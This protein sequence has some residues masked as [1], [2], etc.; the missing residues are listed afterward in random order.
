MERAGGAVPFNSYEFI[1]LFFPLVYVGLCLCRRAGWLRLVKLWLILVSLGFYIWG[2]PS[3]GLLLLGSLV[4][5]YLF[6]WGIGREGSAC[7]RANDGGNARIRVWLVGGIGINVALLLYFK[8]TNFFLDSIAEVLDVAVMRLDI[9]LPLGISFITFQQIAFL[10]DTYR[11]RLSSI[12]IIDYV[13]FMCFFPQLTAGPIVR[14]QEMVPQYVSLGRSSGQ[15]AAGIFLFCIGMF[16]KTVI[17]DTLAIWVRDGYARSDDILGLVDAWI[18]TLSYTFQLYFD[19]SGYSDM[20][21]G[22]AL[23][24]GIRLPINFNSPYQATSLQDFWRRWHMTLSAFLREFVYVPLGGN[25]QGR[26]IT[27]RNLFLTFLI[28]GVWHGAAWGFVIWGAIHGLAL[29]VHRLW[30]ACKFELPSWFG[31]LLTFMVVHVAWVFFRAESADQALDI[32]MSL[33]G[34]NGLGG[35]ETDYSMANWVRALLGAKDALGSRAEQA[36]VLV[37]LLGAIWLPNSMTLLRRFRPSGAALLV[38]LGCGLLSFFH[39]SEFSDFI[40]ARF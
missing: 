18:A 26:L 23:I 17:A 5:N 15:A 19:F 25:R 22:V 2:D 8:Y 7:R 14:Y 34:W 16:K 10:V 30:Q 13:L 33:V 32:L 1:L 21:I 24:M 40:Y 39:V 31:W 6:A 27:S 3:G 11:N 38:A 29:I 4:I 35:F 12:R 36:S 20:A 28:G 37:L 9:V